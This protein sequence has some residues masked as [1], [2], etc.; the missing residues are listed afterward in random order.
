MFR[1]EDYAKNYGIVFTA[2]GMGALLGTL[3]AGRI[4]DLFGSYK[5]FFGVTLVLAA[6]GIVLAVFLLKRQP[7]TALGAE[8]E[9]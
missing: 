1:P 5:L 8:L 7:A 3:T 4:R 9:T 2:F 6:V